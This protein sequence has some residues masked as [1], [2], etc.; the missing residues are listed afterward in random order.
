MRQAAVS[1]TRSWVEER[2]CL[3]AVCGDNGNL[4][5]PPDFALC[6][7]SMKSRARICCH[8]PTEHT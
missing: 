7:S 8:F 3:P 6:P 2:A 4:Y 1:R 5:E